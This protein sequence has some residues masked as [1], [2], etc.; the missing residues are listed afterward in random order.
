M[1]VKRLQFAVFTCLTFPLHCALF[2]DFACGGHTRSSAQSF[3]AILFGFLF[4]VWK[5]NRGTVGERLENH[6]GWHIF[7]LFFSSVFLALKKNTSENRKRCEIV[8]RGLVHRLPI[9]QDRFKVDRQGAEISV[10]GRF[11]HCLV[12]KSSLE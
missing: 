4:F 6:D 5:G 8:I 7:P 1:A 12:V 9:L 3:S 2:A 10:G 11:L